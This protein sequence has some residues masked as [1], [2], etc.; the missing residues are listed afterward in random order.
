MNLLIRII[1]WYHTVFTKNY[2]TIKYFE[3]IPDELKS[4]TLYLLGN[5]NKPWSA[6]F[7]CPCGC[8]ETIQLSLIEQDRPHWRLLSKNLRT[9]LQPSIW[10]TK[11]CESHFFLSN[12]RIKWCE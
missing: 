3:E 5:H 6:A 8:K 9:S 2:Y 7:K 1:H 4:N 10:R 12:N 11:G